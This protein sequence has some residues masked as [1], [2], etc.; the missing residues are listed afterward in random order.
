MNVNYMRYF[1]GLG[2][3]RQGKGGG[4]A[5]TRRDTPSTYP[6]YQFRCYAVVTSISPRRG[7]NL[8]TVHFSVLVNRW[9]ALHSPPGSRVRISPS[10][11]FLATGKNGPLPG[12]PSTPKPPE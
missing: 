1:E 6:L 5:A 2:C 4:R 3:I 10:R 11:P 7:A 9:V 12:F 8:G